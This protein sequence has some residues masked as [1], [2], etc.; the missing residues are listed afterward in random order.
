MYIKKK[1]IYRYNIIRFF[2][3]PDY[4]KKYQLTSEKQS[5]ESIE[6]CE[7]N[8]W[9]VYLFDISYTNN[10]IYAIIQI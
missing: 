9:N 1:I 8:I 2:K 7:S 5:L 6:I 4:I 10:E 3:N